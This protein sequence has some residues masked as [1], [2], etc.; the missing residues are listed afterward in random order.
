MSDDEG[1]SMSGVTHV[2]LVQ[3][4]DGTDH[5]A[6]AD[7]LAQQHLPRIEGVRSVTSGRSISTEAKEDG[8]DWML[9]VRFD[10]RDALAGYLPHAEHRPVAEHIG[11][12]SQRVVVFDID[13]G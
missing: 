7:A 6:E 9:V 3:W 2:V 8:F 10:G 13:E 4:H 11:A 5:S 12:G 1:V